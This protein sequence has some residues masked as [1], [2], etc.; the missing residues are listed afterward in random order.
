MRI[1]LIEREKEK[2]KNKIESIIN[3]NKKEKINNE[4][5]LKKIELSKKK[6]KNI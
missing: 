1:D 3:L 4:E 6:M 2:L 5:Y